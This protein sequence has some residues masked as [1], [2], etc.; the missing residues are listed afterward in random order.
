MIIPQV[1]NF[2]QF[3]FYANNKGHDICHCAKLDSHQP[4]S[5][6]G[7]ELIGYYWSWHIK[8]ELSPKNIP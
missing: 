3:F 6:E 1:H 2:C 4:Y 5:L 8:A 7:V